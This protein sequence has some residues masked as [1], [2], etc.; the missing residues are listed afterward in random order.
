MKNFRSGFQLQ[1]GAAACLGIR[2]MTPAPSDQLNAGSK[3]YDLV[4]RD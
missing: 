3:L 4:H 1:N 2:L